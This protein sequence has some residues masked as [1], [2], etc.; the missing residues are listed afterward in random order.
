MKLNRVV[1]PPERLTAERGSPVFAGSDDPFVV[2]RQ[3]RGRSARVRAARED[4]LSVTAGRDPDVRAPNGGGDGAPD[5]SG[6]ERQSKADVFVETGFT[7]EEYVLAMIESNG[8]RMK[9]QQICEFTGWS[10]GA[11][12]RILSEMEAAGTITRLRIG[13]EKVVFLPDAKPDLS[14]P[15]DSEERSR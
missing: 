7:P 9:Q 15:F 12:S 4:D 1:R 13:R 6:E 11:V 14:I 2:V 3:S 8:R 10:D 5:D